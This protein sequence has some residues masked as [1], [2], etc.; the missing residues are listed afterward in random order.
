MVRDA[1]AEPAQ[2]LLIRRLE[3]LGDSLQEVRIATELEAL[4]VCLIAIEQPY[5]SSQLRQDPL[6]TS[7]TDLL[8]PLPRN[9][10]RSKEPPHPP[11]ARPQSH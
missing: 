2:Y 11:R 9:P 8:L 5:N 6:P 4:G 7:R 3:E 1:Q 10:A